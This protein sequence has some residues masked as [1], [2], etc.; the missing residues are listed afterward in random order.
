MFFKIYSFDA[1]TYFKLLLPPPNI[2]IFWV[3]NQPSPSLLD[4]RLQLETGAYIFSISKMKICI[5][6]KYISFF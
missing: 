3:A 4:T 5:Q 1:S 2:R 6:T